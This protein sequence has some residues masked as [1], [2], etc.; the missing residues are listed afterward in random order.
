V[1]GWVGA[2]VLISGC[3]RIDYEL[4]GDPHTG[5][6]RD[7]AAVDGAVSIRDA[8]TLG[9][10]GLPD[11]GGEPD[12]RTFDS[13][14]ER[15]AGTPPPAPCAR[16]IE[17]MVGVDTFGDTC[18]GVDAIDG[19]PPAGTREIVY[20]FTAPTSGGYTFR[21]MNGYP[22]QVLDDRCVRTDVCAGIYGTSIAAGETVYILI[23]EESGSCGTFMLSITT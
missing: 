11:G 18:T 9:D 12:A 23:E 17:V 19:C 14:F 8:S 21:A 22:I 20:R 1:I 10:G 3:G 7:A 2:L 6:T 15:D 13:G 5:A 16:A 4:V